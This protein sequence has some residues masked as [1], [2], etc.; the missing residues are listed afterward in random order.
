MADAITIILVVI[1]AIAAATPLIVYILQRQRKALAYDILSVSPLLTG[2]ELQGKVTIQFNHRREVQNIYLLIIKLINSGNFPITASDFEGPIK[3]LFG[4]DDEILS[5]E[6][7]EKN[8]SNLDPKLDVTPDKL[9]LDPLLLNSGDY[10]IIK[11][12]LTSYSGKIQIN[13]RIAGVTD[14]QKVKESPL[15]VYMTI[16]GVVLTLTGFSFAFFSNFALGIIL[17]FVGYFVFL[18][19]VLMRRKSSK[20]ISNE[21]IAVLC[22]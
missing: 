11:T 16:A 6:I 10:I 14:F 22:L 13:G 19:G 21:R 15:P 9:V 4:K 8:P 7:T 12:L 17:L 20:N 5:G 2:N 18:S 1:T 3:I